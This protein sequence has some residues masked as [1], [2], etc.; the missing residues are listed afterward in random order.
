MST[1]WSSSV[2]RKQSSTHAP[3][4]RL[5][6]NTAVD[7]KQKP[8]SSGRIFRTFVFVWTVWRGIWRSQGQRLSQRIIWVCREGR[9][10]CSRS[11]LCKTNQK[12]F[13][14][15]VRP[16]F[17]YSQWI[18]KNTNYAIWSVKP[19]SKHVMVGTGQQ[20][21]NF[22]HR[23]VL[24]HVEEWTTFLGSCCGKKYYMNSMQTCNSVT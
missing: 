23:S 12:E 24:V 13:K 17:C 14:T 20:K 21:T 2:S 8:W 22:L 18:A 15:A 3:S 6:T 19:Q 1:S 5:L 4:P 9:I 16:V 11:N 10:W 7:S